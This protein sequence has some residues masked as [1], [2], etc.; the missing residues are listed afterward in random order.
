MKIDIH[1]HILPRNLPD[2]EKRYGCQGFLSYHSC[3]QKGKIELK[4]N[5]KHFRIVEEN[6]WNADARISEMDQMGV[7]IQ[8]LSTVPVMFSYW[9]N[10][11][12]ALDVSQIINRDLNECI[13]KHPKRFVGLGNVPMQDPQ[14][15]ASEMRRCVKEYNF[16]GVQIG[17]HINDWNLDAPE[18]LPFWKEANDLECAVFIHPWDM[19]LGGRMSKYW[20]PWLVGMPGETA[21]AIQCM[22][23]GGVLQRFPK[24]KVCFAHG[25]GAF[26]FTVGRFEKGFKC[27]PDLCA[28]DTNVPPTKQLGSFYTDS[29]VHSEKS[30]QLLVDVI[31]EDKIMLGTDYPFPLGEDEAGKLIENHPTLQQSV[32]EKMLFLNALN[33]L[34]IDK[35]NYF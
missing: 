12:D 32:K 8:A 23:F 6:C 21:H 27:R 11:K 30:L 26:P 7:T 31:G 25:G 29:L 1:N 5:G 2:L 33:F 20:A 3:N 9:A 15:A 22:L 17:S 24:L 14:L 16:S 34:G 4:K 19:Q 35:R 13:K 10:A 18:L 28:T